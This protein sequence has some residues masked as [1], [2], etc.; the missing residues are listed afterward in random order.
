MSARVHVVGA[1]I[2]G[3]ACAWEL[4][5]DG[6]EVH[7]IERASTGSG[8]TAA[9]MGHVLVLDDSPAQLVLTRYSQML[10]DEL[11]LP[12]EVERQH[13]G[14]LWLAED[15]A[16]WDA[17]ARKAGMYLRH[18]VP[19]EI[20]DPRALAE[21]EP[22]LNPDLLGALRVPGDSVVYPPATAAYFGKQAVARGATPIT[23]DV[24]HVDA[25]GTV[26]TKSGQRLQ[27]DAVVLCPGGPLDAL[28]PDWTRA[29]RIRLRRG[30]LVITDRQPPLCRHQLVELG[31]LTSA[32]GTEDDSVAFN[33]QPR[34]TGQ[35]L[36]GSSRQF[37][38]EASQPDVAVVAAMI[39]RAIDFV[40]ALAQVRALRSWVGF[41]A[42]T[43]DHLPL[44]GPVPGHRNVWV[45]TGHEGLGIT[46]SLGTARLVADGLQNRD[47]EIDPAPYRPERMAA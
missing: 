23:A 17:V 39:R 27:G 32:H 36:L 18:G 12:D 28:L 44:V 47:S 24:D 42:A 43:D 41:R 15:R 4:A 33:L 21:L 2:V 7:W 8:A 37:G 46:T 45:A 19:A 26:H 10:W 22:G 9:G 11:E 13:T 20:L 30:H 29:P 38:H 6:F 14:T 16:Q 25:D 31:Y 40:P 5:R 35:L 3:A 34:A 1:G